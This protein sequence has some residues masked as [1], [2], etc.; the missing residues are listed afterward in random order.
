MRKF[1]ESDE[2]YN[3]TNGFIRQYPEINNNL[4]A[5]IVQDQSKDRYIRDLN[6]FKG[7]H[8]TA[9]DTEKWTATAW[10]RNSENAIIFSNDTSLTLE[11]AFLFC[12]TRNATLWIPKPTD[13]LDGS[14]FITRFESSG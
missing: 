5:I 7:F 14:D 8:F 13:Y 4:I 11:E 10:C 3:K 1:E 6:K 12:L 2:Q 9:I